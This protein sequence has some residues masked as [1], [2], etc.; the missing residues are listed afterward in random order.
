MRNVPEDSKPVRIK[1]GAYAVHQSVVVD[2]LNLPRVGAQIGYSRAPFVRNRMLAI[3]RQRPNLERR[4]EYGPLMYA[5]LIIRKIESLEA[6][7]AGRSVQHC[8]RVLLLKRH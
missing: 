2:R 1:T 8:I 7:N 5:G 4:K 6:S 3:V